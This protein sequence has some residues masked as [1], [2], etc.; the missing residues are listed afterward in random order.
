[1]GFPDSFDSRT[2][3]NLNSTEYFFLVLR[4]ILDTPDSCILHSSQ[5]SIFSGEVQDYSLTSYGHC[6]HSLILLALNKQHIR[7]QELDTYFNYL[8]ELAFYIFRIN[9]NGLTLE[10]IE[11]FRH[12]YEKEYLVDSHDK[13]QETLINSKILIIKDGKLNFR[14]KYLYFFYVAKFLSDKSESQI[15]KGVI[16]NLCEN[17]HSEKNANILIFLIHHTKDRKIIDEIL[18]QTMYV[19]D[20]VPEETLEVKELRFL[21]GLFEAIPKLI[22]EQKNVENERKERLRQKDQIEK[23]RISQEESN[24]TIASENKIIRD[25][26]RSYRAVEIIGQILR[27]YHGSLKKE[28]LKSLS[29]QAI[30][31]GLRYLKFYLNA[32]KHTKEKL[33]E[34]MES[35][36]QKET[37][38]NQKEIEKEAQKIFVGLCHQMAHA[39]VWKISNSLGETKLMPV[40]DEV[41][42]EIGD[43]PS[44][45]LI[46]II[47]KLEYTKQIPRSEI[48]E[49]G[50]ELESSNPFSFRILQHILIQH[51]YLHKVDYKERQ[52]ISDVLKIPIRVQL[53][54]DEKKEQRL[55]K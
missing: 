27:N 38:K 13:L 25:V 55:D 45:K 52:W 15:C 22:L 14:Y 42:K 24:E 21:N 36:I 50:K 17:I 44:L 40:Y 12:G 48:G 23:I 16:E 10:E 41:I 46:R 28:D 33:L 8:R 11:D 18:L 39:V 19:F 31:V 49:L 20:G 53:R 37:K 9:T 26:V 35:L 43:F 1:M 32:L 30:K 34:V 2:A 29:T 7:H 54:I 5:V 3:S 51:L 4:S 6:Y 47:L